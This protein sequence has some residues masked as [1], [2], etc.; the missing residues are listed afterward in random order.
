MC[1]QSSGVSVYGMLKATFLRCDIYSNV[2][3]MGGIYIYGG[4][5]TFLSCNIYSNTATSDGGGV[6]IENDNGVVEFNGCN[7]YDNA[8]EVVGARSSPAMTAFPAG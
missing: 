4:D 8:A 3:S 7:I 1:L 2:G 6:Y 5:I